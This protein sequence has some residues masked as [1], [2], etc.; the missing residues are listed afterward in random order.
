MR[1]LY[2]ELI[3]LTL[4]GCVRDTWKNFDILDKCSGSYQTVSDDKTQGVYFLEHITHLYAVPTCSC[5][6]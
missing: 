5:D 2:C 3:T 1:N 4:L 6:C